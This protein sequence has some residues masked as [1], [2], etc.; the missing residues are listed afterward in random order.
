L[1]KTVSN[2]FVWFWEM[3]Y[4][5]IAIAGLIHFFWFLSDN[6]GILDWIKEIA[7]FEY[8]KTAFNDYH[9][10]PYFWWNILEEVAWRPPIPGT[11]ALIANPETALFSPFTPL[12]YLLSAKVYIKLYIIIQ[13]LLG[14]SGLFAIKRKLNWNN[15]QFRTFAILFLFSPIIMQHI[16]VAYFTWYNFYLFP[17]LIYFVADRRTMVGIVGA[18]AVLGL[19]VLQGGIYIV[20]YIG[21]FYILYEVFHVLFEREWK[22]IIRI[23]I[24]PLLAVLLALVRIYI[25]G[26]AYGDYARPWVEIDGYNLSFFLFYA[27]IP[28]VTIPPLDLFF[29][30]D[31]LG[32]SLTPHDSGQF[33][34][35]SI[36]M[37]AVVVAKYRKIVRNPN[38]QQ[39]NGLNYNAVFIA[40]SF[41]FI[42]SFYQI[43][44][45]IMRAVSILDIPLF[46]SIK[47]HGIRFIMGSCFGFA[48]LL[49]NYSQEIWKEFHQFVDTRFWQITKKILERSFNIIL[50]GLGLAILFLKVFKSNIITKFNEIIIAAFNNTGHF[51]LRNRME[52]MEENSLEFYFYRFEIAYTAIQHWLLIIFSVLLIIF[53]LIYIFDKK[54]KLFESIVIQFPSLKFEL[55]LAIPLIFSTVMWTNLA[56]SVPYE[57]HEILPAMPPK[58]VVKSDENVNLPT[59]EVTPK[60]IIITQSDDIN[61]KGYV[62]PQTP[63]TDSKHFDIISNNATFINENGRLALKPLDNEPIEMQFR[64]E[65]VV[66]VLVITI[67]SW[68]LVLMFMLIELI[69]KRKTEKLY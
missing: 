19:I 14:V 68:G 30:S 39:Q 10:L 50:F 49:A 69:R 67:I 55:L 43:W 54:R 13:F 17:W 65:R 36:V 20:Q 26:Y 38:S 5:Y 24:I 52:G 7:Y 21:L 33:W 25:T 29:H 11:A 53:L 35:L 34:G 58:I 28:T 40:A 51:W 2:R 57:S 12:L 23:L 61:V 37:L 48:L 46:E 1:S 66:K 63:A 8:F 9:T 18:A 62:F 6:V 56:S 16:S 4:F 3:G 47:N 22:R 15:S 41:L 32:W 42:I 27:L 59:L 45:L 64:T 31:F 44:Y 60:N